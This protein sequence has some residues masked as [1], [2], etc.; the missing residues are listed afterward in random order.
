MPVTA[1]KGDDSHKVV[2]EVFDP[3]QGRAVAVFRDDGTLDSHVG[4]DDPGGIR[5]LRAD[6]ERFD[7]PGR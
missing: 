1:M 4:P 2:C 6:L 3:S 7:S 5:E